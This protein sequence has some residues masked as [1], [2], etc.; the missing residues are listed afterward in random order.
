MKKLYSILLILSWVNHNINSQNIEFIFGPSYGEFGQEVLV[1]VLVNNFV[2]V[3][4]LQFQIFVDNSLVTYNRVYSSYN[5]SLDSSDFRYDQDSILIGTASFDSALTIPDNETFFEIVFIIDTA[6]TQLDTSQI[7]IGFDTTATPSF[8]FR[9]DSLFL[10]RDRVPITSNCQDIIV[11]QKLRVVQI[12]IE[13]NVCYSDER[14]TIDL[15]IEGGIPPYQ[16][17][18]SNGSNGANLNDLPAGQYSFTVRDNIGNEVTDT[19]EITE[20]ERIEL[21]LGM[22]TLICQGDIL[23]LTIGS[24]LY[25]SVLWQMNG[26]IISTAPETTVT[27]AGE[28]VAF[29][30]DEMGCNVSDTIQIESLDD[31]NL[32]LSTNENVVCPESEILLTIE[33]GQVVE[34]LSGLELLDFSGD[35]AMPTAYIPDTTTFILLGENE[36]F[37]DTAELTIAVYPIISAA[38]PDTCIL[39]GQSVELSASGGDMYLWNDSLDLLSDV[40]IPDPIARPVDS[41]I[42]EVLIIDKNGCQVLDSVLVAVIENA[43]SIIE[44]I[45]V[46]TPNNDGKNDA[47]VFKGLEKFPFSDIQIFNRY[48]QSV[49]S[50]TPYK[51]NWDGRS[52]GEELPAGSYFYVLIVDNVEIKSAVTI[53]RE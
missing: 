53:I 9:L 17:D 41:T 2:E 40:T 20:G 8:A 29:V 13:N 52:K 28:Y 42:F 33:G 45:N 36:C 14:G 15:D 6:S 50:A 19:V 44:P 12:D 5:N 30:W 1:P 51:N 26:N 23:D 38:G 46:I 31:I 48:G 25:D 47:L 11:H 34:W 21:D 10:P 3:D 35:P 37:T 7:K 32:I 39:S 49:F 22:D 16:V 27:Q 24:I 4:G 18:W 43:S